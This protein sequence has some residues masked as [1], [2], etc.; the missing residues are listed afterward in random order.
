MGTDPTL[1]RGLG[2]LDTRAGGGVLDG[3]A[4]LLQAI[5]DG[6]GGAPVLGG[7]SGSAGGKDGL[8]GA[9]TVI[10]LEAHELGGHACELGG[11]RLL[12]HGKLDTQLRDAHR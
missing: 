7:T 9:S 11:Q 12:D 1:K 8:G 3:E 6:V 10:A 4:K 2:P 5:A